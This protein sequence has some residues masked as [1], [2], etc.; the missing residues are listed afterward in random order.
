MSTTIKYLSLQVLE[1]SSEALKADLKKI[2]ETQRQTY[3]MFALHE[4]SVVSCVSPL[5]GV[6]L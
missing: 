5:I 1:D 2:T 6:I 4:K 3:I